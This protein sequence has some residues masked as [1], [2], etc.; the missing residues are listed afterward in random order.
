MLIFQIIGMV[1]VALFFSFLTLLLL[2]SIFRRD[3]KACVTGEAMPVLRPVPIP[4]KN[5]SFFM[6]VLV[7]LFDVRKWQLVENWH[8]KLKD[9]IEIVLPRAFVFDGASIPRPLWFLL[10]PVGLLLIP[11]L[12]HDYGYKHDQLWTKDENGEIK[13]YQEKAG[14]KYWDTLFKNIGKEINGFAV[15]D[16][17][18]W[19]GV[20]LA[21]R[22]A[23]HRY[24]KINEPAV[25]PSNIVQANNS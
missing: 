2:Y 18:A 19:L 14:K 17:I 22:C 7:W 5:R 3:A 21:G 8:F 15:I 12:I 24:R 6:R 13:P 11:G 9:D 23:W 16:F 4:T 10:S 1:V 20:V 25:K